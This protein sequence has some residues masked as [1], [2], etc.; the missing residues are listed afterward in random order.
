[1]PWF[2][3]ESM[4]QNRKLG[5]CDK[6]E[7]FKAAGM[8]YKINVEMARQSYFPFWIASTQTLAKV[9]RDNG[10]EVGWVADLGKGEKG[11]MHINEILN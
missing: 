2:F 5:L 3:V 1:M 4:L 11:P 6:P 8:I 9:C 10:A 7:Y